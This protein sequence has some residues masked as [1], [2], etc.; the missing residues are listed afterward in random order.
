MAGPTGTVEYAQHHLHLRVWQSLPIPQGFSTSRGLPPVCSQ[1]PWEEAAGTK[2]N[3]YQ[4]KSK[5]LPI[6][7]HFPGGISECKPVIDHSLL[8]TCTFCLQLSLPVA[9][10]SLFLNSILYVNCRKGIIGLGCC[11]ATKA[12]YDDP[13]SLKKTAGQ[14]SNPVFKSFH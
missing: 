9:L 1:Q 14:I 8:C 2:M 3:Y 5:N 11:M 4:F 7:Q 6:Q 10:L 13:E 12:H